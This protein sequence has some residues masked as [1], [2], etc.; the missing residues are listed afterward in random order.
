MQNNKMQIRDGFGTVGGVGSVVSLAF[1]PYY[2]ETWRIVD[3]D[4]QGIY[5]KRCYRGRKV[6]HFPFPLVC[7]FRILNGGKVC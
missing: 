3:I 5:L 1:P 4:G 6:R 7:D 2:G